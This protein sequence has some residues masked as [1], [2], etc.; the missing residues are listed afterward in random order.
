M[1]AV[2]IIL[3][4]LTAAVWGYQSLAARSVPEGASL[5]EAAW[6]HAVSTNGN[7]IGQILT[8]AAR[9]LGNLPSIYSA[10]TSPQ[11]QALQRK[12]LASGV[13][14]GSIE[15][16]LAVQAFV[17]F[18]AAETCIAMLVFQV[19]GSMLIGGAIVAFVIAYWPW[20][21]VDKRTKALQKGVD[22]ELPVFVE[23]LL[24]PIE[25]GLGISA[26][27]AFTAERLTGPVAL[28]I[29]NLNDVLSSR[30]M[31]MPEAYQLAAA[32]LGTPEA[33]SFL[34]ALLRSQEDGLEI[35]STL[36]AQVESLNKATHQRTRA[37]L[38]QLSL[39][40]VIRFVIHLL[41]FLL[42]L[43]LLPGLIAMAGL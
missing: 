7:M 31:D 27:L 10:A 14:G 21:E 11:Y 32:R 26:A 18:I 19:Q 33:A 38:K 39:K 28:E 41:P 30:A 43:G 3:L 16:Y 23:L 25:S 1:I 20:N 15:V 4:T 42:A 34:D 36:R 12:I 2:G 17:I 13:F 35:S 5:S 8:R 40:L 24:M 6:A 22:E 37:M 29:R 9:P